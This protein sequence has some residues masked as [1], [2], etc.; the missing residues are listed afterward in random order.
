MIIYTIAL[1]VAAGMNR[2]TATMLGGGGILWL[3]VLRALFSDGEPFPED[4]SG[5]GFFI[6][7]LVAVGLFGAVLLGPRA[8][9]RPLTAMD[10]TWLLA[11]QGIRV[12]F[13]ATFLLWAGQDILPRTFGIIDG[14]THITAGLL[15]L[16]AAWACSKG[17]GATTLPW[18]ANIFGLGDILIVAS[19]IAFVLLGDIGPHH[20]MMYAVFGAAPVWL[21]LHVVSIY[22]LVFSTSP[23][24]HTTAA[25]L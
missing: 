10:Q 6:I 9:R 12:I 23:A 18:I 7:V 1:F 17:K 20:P 21:W 24:E 16:A 11:P 19:S 2:R 25:T 14:F 22:R 3:I 13:G 5:L 15:G 4:I 8:L